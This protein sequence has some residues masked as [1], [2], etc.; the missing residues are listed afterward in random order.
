MERILGFPACVA[1]LAPKNFEDA[2]G[3]LSRVPPR[4]GAVE[5]RLDLAA[6]RISP[7]A[8]L[9]LDPRP[10]IVTYRTAREG[11][12]FTGSPEE[13]RRSVQSAYDAGALVDVEIATGLLADPAFLPDRR[14]VI[15]S[16]HGDFEISERLIERFR[17]IPAAALKLVCARLS[18]YAELFSLL[19][20]MRAENRRRPAAFFALGRA[21]LASRVLAPRFGCAL[22]YGSVGDPTADGQPSLEE[23]LDVYRADR[24]DADGRLF[25]VYGGNVTRSL[26]PRIHNALFARRGSPDLYFPASSTL[27]SLERESAILRELSDLLLL[28]GPLSGASVTNPFKEAAL[29]LADGADETACE[30]GAANTLVRESDESGNDRFLARNT[31]SGAVFDALTE[32]GRSGQVMLVLGAGGA[33]AAAAHAGLRAGN[34]VR[35]AARDARKAASLAA[36]MQAEAIPLADLPR[37]DSGILVNATPLAAPEEERPFPSALLRRR[38]LVVDFAYRPDGETALVAEARGAGC[39]VTDGLEI[40]ARQAV[41]Q[42]RLFGVAD[43]TLEEILEIARPR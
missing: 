10:A 41:G 34:R 8:L 33:A 39:P 43:A 5:Y 6:V 36:R 14:R 20:L 40:L 26:S 22:T 28:G 4:A 9:D 29:H 38:P 35:I 31:D 17:E 30:V 27:D 11:G 1:S 15:A 37:A 32:R 21:G 13:Y 3:L 16:R 2:R 19:D 7:R 24:P 23:L 25:A 12:G 18:S 42:A